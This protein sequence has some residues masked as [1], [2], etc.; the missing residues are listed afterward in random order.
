MD[1]SQ[2]SAAEGITSL[3]YKKYGAFNTIIC[4]ND[5]LE[6][7]NEVRDELRADVVLPTLNIS[8]IVGT[9]SMSMTWVKCTMGVGRS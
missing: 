1:F 3:I 4:D 9:G 2:L 8:S 7:A 6:R 5:R